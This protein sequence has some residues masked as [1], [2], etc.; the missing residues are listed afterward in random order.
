MI[1]SEAIRVNLQFAYKALAHNR[2]NAH[3]LAPPNAP[4]NASLRSAR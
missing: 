2:S 4:N 3:P 1:E